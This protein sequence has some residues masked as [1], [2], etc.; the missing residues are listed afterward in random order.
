MPKP[1]TNL[2]ILHPSQVT[3]AAFM[4]ATA[5]ESYPLFAYFMPEVRQRKAKLPVVIEMILRHGM[6]YGD[7]YSTSPRLER[8]AVWLS[9]DFRDTT[10][11]RQLR[12]GAL[13]LLFKLPLQ[14]LLTQRKTVRF[15]SRVHN[16]I[17]P[18]P[19]RYLMLLGVG[20][21]AQG[22]GHAARLLRPL[23]VQCDQ[24]GL[25]CYLETHMASNIPIYRHYGFDIVEEVIVPG[26]QIPQWSMLRRPQD[27]D[28]GWSRYRG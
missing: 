3:H 21:H 16:R 22:C 10:L 13:P 9:A 1:A 11:W 7:V 26:A 18:F 19:H 15:I 5:F 27:A 25:P 20:P 4:L 12:S 24:D 14:L 6:R 2:S 23:L 17:A 8:I 28:T